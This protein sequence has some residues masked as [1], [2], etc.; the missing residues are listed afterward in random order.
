M[1]IQ[2]KTINLAVIIVFLFTPF[3]SSNS[4]SASI[5]ELK[6][7]KIYTQSDLMVVKSINIGG[8]DLTR[9]G[10]GGSIQFGSF[11]TLARSSINTHFPGSTF[12]SMPLLSSSSLN[13]IDILFLVST[14]GNTTAITALSNEEQTALLNFV[15]NGGS[16]I[17]LIDNDAFGG[18]VSDL[19][20]ES[21]IDPFSMDAAGTIVGSVTV[22]FTQP[23]NYEITNGPYG[24]INS[25]VQYFPGSISNS[26]PY[27]TILASNTH[28]GALAIIPPNKIQSGSG[29][30]VIFSDANSFFDNSALGFFTQNENLFLNQYLR[31][32]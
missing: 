3:F 25:F 28:G 4:I 23:Q 5:L 13:G 29:P 7:I 9:G 19:T 24:I 32:K 2:N 15:N 26:G 14:K 11:F 16:V 6:P 27:A 21:L 22:N 17:I 10:N 20:N 30:V 8:F 12:I 18:S 31:Q 1:N